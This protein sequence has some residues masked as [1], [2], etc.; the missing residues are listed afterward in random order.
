M[1]KKDKRRVVCVG[2]ESADAQFFSLQL[3]QPAD[4]GADKDEKIV[5]SLYGRYEH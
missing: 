5:P 4:I 2:S 1:L 3:F